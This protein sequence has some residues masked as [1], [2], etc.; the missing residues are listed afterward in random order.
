MYDGLTAPANPKPVL[1]TP[2]EAD[3][4][5][6]LASYGVM[7]T[8][9]EDAFD[10]VV[11][12]ARVLFDTP[13]A[14][15]SLVDH[16][17]QWFKAR[18]GIDVAQ[19]AREDSFCSHAMEGDGVFVVPDARLDPRFSANPLVVGEPNIRFY[20]G[21][22][23]RGAGGHSLG[24]VCVIS[25]DP[26]GEFS[27]EDQAKLQILASIVGTEMELKKQAQ[28]AHKLVFD[29][30]MELRE[31][32]YRIKNTVEYANLLADVQ[33]EEM[34]EEKLA[35]VAMAAWKQYSAA[36]GILVTS[37]RALRR[38]MTAE[39]YQELLDNMPGFAM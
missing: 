28:K 13:M 27:G 14:A 36:G 3:R 7:D 4:L 11:A 17:R 21:A 8:G 39:A 24:A 9:P 25:S 37:V 16:D 5:A 33:S 1:I 19:T 31:A 32:H 38:R 20:A 15:V 35:A 23:L 30:D 2:T 34:S 12:L 18:A 29:K 10:R 26:R 22:P 6:E